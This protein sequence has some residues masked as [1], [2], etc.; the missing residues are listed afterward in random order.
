MPRREL[1]IRTAFAPTRSS[2][3]QLQTAYEMVMPQ[4]GYVNVNVEPGYRR[5]Q[6]RSERARCS[7][8]GERR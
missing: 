3:I 5:G 6:E 7:R 4:V 8:G 2:S 1:I